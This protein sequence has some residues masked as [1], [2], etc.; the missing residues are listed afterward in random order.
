[1]MALGHLHILQIGTIAL[2]NAFKPCALGDGKDGDVLVCLLESRVVVRHPWGVLSFE[3]DLVLGP[4]RLLGLRGESVP[5]SCSLVG[6]SL[7][8]RCLSETR[9]R[10]VTWSSHVDIHWNHLL[11]RL[12]A[13]RPTECASH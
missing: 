6:V 2:F 12:G 8:N 4:V 10:V 13:F 5:R 3:V 11:A 7:A 9:N 1:M